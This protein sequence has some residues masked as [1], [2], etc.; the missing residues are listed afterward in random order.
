MHA[1]QQ[2]NISLASFIRVMASAAN[3]R[4]KP[5]GRNWKKSEKPLVIVLSD[6]SH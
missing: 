6:R 1:E 2:T 3:V 5:T 4:T